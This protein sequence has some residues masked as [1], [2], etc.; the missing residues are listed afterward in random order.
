M[1]IRMKYYIF[2]IVLGV[3]LLLTYSGLAEDKSQQDE[4]QT[5]GGWVSAGIGGSHFQPV[6]MVVSLI[7]ITIIFLR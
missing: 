6:S 7:A 2:I 4:V 5:S 3:F 1:F